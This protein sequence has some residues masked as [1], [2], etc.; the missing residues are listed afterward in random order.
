MEYFEGVHKV[1]GDYY[2]LHTYTVIDYYYNHKNGT[3]FYGA[4]MTGWFSGEY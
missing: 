1:E 4:G 2:S 3:D